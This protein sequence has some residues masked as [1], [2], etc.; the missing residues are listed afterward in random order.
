MEVNRDWEDI[1][2]SMKLRAVSLKWASKLTQLTTLTKQNKRTQ[3]Q[4]RK[5]DTT[6][7][8]QKYKDERINNYTPT[9]W[10]I[11]KNG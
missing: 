11:Y 1:K 3:N 7:K 6:P 10:T 9:I 8:P 4:K 2:R 5:R